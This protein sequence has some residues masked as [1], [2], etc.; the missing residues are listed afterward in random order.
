MYAAAAAAGA[1]AT[2]LPSRWARACLGRGAP[3]PAGR[4]VRDGA[5]AV[6]GLNGRG[7]RGGPGPRLSAEHHLGMALL[8]VA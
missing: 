7:W 1:P 8:R 6:K 5:V 4:A 2:L 3:S